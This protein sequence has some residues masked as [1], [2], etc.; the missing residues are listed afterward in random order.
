MTNRDKQFLYD[1]LREKNEVIAVLKD[2]S[3]KKTQY[4]NVLKE[5][6][7]LREKVIET[8]NTEIKELKSK[9]ETNKWWRFW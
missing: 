7:D 3:I 9:N 4:I 6:I 8:L 1:K 2:L 5:G